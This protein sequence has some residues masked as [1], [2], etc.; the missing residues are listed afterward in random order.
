M[1]ILTGASSGRTGTVVST[2]GNGRVVDVEHERPVLLTVPDGPSQVVRLPYAPEE[3][4]VVEP[5]PVSV[6]APGNRFRVTDRGDEYD[7]VTGVVRSEPFTSSDGEAFVH[8]MHDDGSITM[9]ETSRLQRDVTLAP[10][11]RVR[12]TDNGRMGTVDYTAVETDL[13]AEQPGM[14]PVAWD[15]DDAWLTSPHAL[16]VIEHLPAADVPQQPEMTAN[17]GGAN[18]GRIT[19]TDTELHDV[20]TGWRA[21]MLDQFRREHPLADADFDAQACLMVAD[22]PE[23]ARE[24]LARLLLPPVHTAGHDVPMPAWATGRESVVLG[25]GYE[26]SPDDL[27]V[28]FY[29]D[30]LEDEAAKVTVEQYVR[31]DGRSMPASV[32]VEIDEVGIRPRSARNVASAL[33]EAAETLEK[34]RA[35]R[36]L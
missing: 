28:R 31:A 4:E 19:M 36:A 35:L 30:T 7:G 24:G 14:V 21:E 10:G 9:W 29:K 23:G 12:R 33:I 13:L 22:S 1:R 34:A 6:L 8:V 5:E 20:T 16:D 2:R 15:G 32:R 26:P 27:A 11:T 17:D 18:E 25:G 3:L